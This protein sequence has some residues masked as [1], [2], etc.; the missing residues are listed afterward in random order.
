MTNG[1]LSDPGVTD[2]NRARPTRGTRLLSLAYGAGE[3]EALAEAAPAEDA[4]TEETLAADALVEDTPA[5]EAL[6]VEAL[7]ADALAEGAL[8]GEAPVGPTPMVRTTGALG[9]VS[10]PADGSVP[11]TV[12]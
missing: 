5:A 9:L 12:P 3:A 10:V 4:A 1:D 6:A 11:V 2:P 7:A 8:A